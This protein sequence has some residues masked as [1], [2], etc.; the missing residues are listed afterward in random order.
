MKKDLRFQKDGTF[1]VIQFTDTHWQNGLENDQKTLRLIERILDMERPDFVTFTGDNLYIGSRNNP[2][3]QAKADPLSECRKLFAPVIER[4]IPWAF[5]FGNHDVENLD[6]SREGMM[7]AM[8]EYESCYSEIGPMDIGGVGNFIIQIKGSKDNRN[9]GLLYFFDSGADS[10]LPTGGYAYITH[11]QIQWYLEQSNKLTQENEGKP[12][13]ALAFFHIP[14]PEYNEV[15]DYQPC[16][17]EKNEKVCAPKINTGLFSA[18]LISGDIMGI[19]VGHDHTNDYYGDLYGIR[20]CYGRGSGYGGYGKE[21]FL[22]GARVIEMMEG[23]ND[24]NTW[25][26]LGDGTLI[27]KPKVHEPTGYDS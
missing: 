15:W 22:R 18:M 13:P 11:N 6:I 1:K 3:K 24:F 25:I 21:D 17:G 10:D 5:V 9:A 26:R 12:L 20:L 4:E 7:K 23:K 19:F 8:M 16:Y 27:D 2:S 14:L